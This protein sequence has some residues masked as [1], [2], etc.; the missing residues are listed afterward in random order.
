MELRDFGHHRQSRL[1][2]QLYPCWL[3]VVPA[4]DTMGMAQHAVLAQIA[5]HK[6]NSCWRRSVSVQMFSMIQRSPAR[7]PFGHRAFFRFRRLPFGFH[8]R[9]EPIFVRSKRSAQ[10]PDFR[11]SSDREQKAP[12][13]SSIDRICQRMMSVLQV[14]LVWPNC[15][16]CSGDA[17][18]IAV[19][20][21]H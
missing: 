3:S 6:V 2:E 15:A 17:R 5:H 7:W 9:V 8:E 14:T 13:E 4:A 21:G 11:Q 10:N 16:Y 20:K 18:F 19:E 12:A 1:R